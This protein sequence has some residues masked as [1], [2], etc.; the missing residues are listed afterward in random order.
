MLIGCDRG[1]TFDMD[2]GG[3]A[4]GGRDKRRMLDGS[5]TGFGSDIG[6]VLGRGGLACDDGEVSWVIWVLLV[7]EVGRRLN[8]RKNRNFK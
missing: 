6:S 1:M 4:R 2:L 5:G 8:S 3:E 7:A